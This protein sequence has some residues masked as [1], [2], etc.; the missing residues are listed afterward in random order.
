MLLKGC[1]TLLKA[2]SKLQF[3]TETAPFLEAHDVIGVVL[4]HIC[5]QSGSFLRQNTAQPGG[6]V[7]AVGAVALR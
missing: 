5:N 4:A 7:P 3:Q 2:M 1:V 6:D